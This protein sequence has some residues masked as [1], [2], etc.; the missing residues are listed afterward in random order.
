LKIIY[1]NGLFNLLTPEI[2]LFSS[3]IVIYPI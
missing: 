1:I 2:N 3:L